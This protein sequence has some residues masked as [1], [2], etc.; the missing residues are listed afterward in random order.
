MDNYTLLVL[1]IKALYESNLRKAQESVLLGEDQG[2]PIVHAEEWTRG[3]LL[4]TY[5]K[6]LKDRP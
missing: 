3:D 1:L 2:N 4:L 6:F 5:E